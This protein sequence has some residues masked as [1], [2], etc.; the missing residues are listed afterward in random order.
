MSE[1]GTTSFSG[2]DQAAPVPAVQNLYHRETRMSILTRLGITGMSRSR[3]YERTDIYLEIPPEYTPIQIT[4]NPL[5]KN[6]TEDKLC[7]FYSSHPLLEQNDG[8][9]KVTSTKPF[10]ASMSLSPMMRMSCSRTDASMFSDLP[11]RKR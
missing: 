9:R 5:T 1:D 8:F 11:E 2:K 10:V 6:S 7:N 4:R 3:L